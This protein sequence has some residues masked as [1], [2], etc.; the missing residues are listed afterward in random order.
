MTGGIS[1]REVL[2]SFGRKVRALRLARGMSQE[3][4]GFATGLDQTYISD[5]ELG[6][7]NV[8]LLAIDSLA[9]ALGVSLMDLFEEVT[10]VKL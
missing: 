4:L 7:R 6:R 1:D 2:R 5:V 10:R 3:K 8:S 9:Q